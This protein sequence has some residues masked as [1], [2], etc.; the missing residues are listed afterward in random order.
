MSRSTHL[1]AAQMLPLLRRGFSGATRV[2][3]ADSDPVNKAERAKA[4]KPSQLGGSSSTIILQVLEMTVS[5]RSP[6]SNLE[7]QSRRPT[8]THFLVNSM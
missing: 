5:A 7:F 6:R 8:L 4:L 3:G 1:Y 2:L